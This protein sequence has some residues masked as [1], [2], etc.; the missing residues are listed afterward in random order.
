MLPSASSAGLVT[1]WRFSAMGTATLTGCGL[2]T[3][4][5]VETT[6][7]PDVAPSGTRA[8]TKSSELITTVPSTSPNCTRGR[9]SSGGRS[10]LP[11]IRISAPGR[12][13]SG[14]TRSMCGLPLTFFLPN[15]RLE[16]P[17]GPSFLAAHT[18]RKGNAIRLEDEYA[19]QDASR[20]AHTAPLPDRRERSPRLPECVPAAAPEVASGCRKHERV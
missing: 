15:K 4:P 11:K 19:L 6:T 8:T 12:A 1:G 10:P 20:P 17:N 5:L 2:L 16:I 3:W 9:L 13:A 18:R 14:D 7:G